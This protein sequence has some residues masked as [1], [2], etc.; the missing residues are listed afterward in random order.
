METLMRWPG[1]DSG[2]VIKAHSVYGL[3]SSLAGGK[4]GLEHLPRDGC[5]P[6]IVG[7]RCTQGSDGA[8]GELVPSPLPTS[9]PLLVGALEAL[10]RVPVE[11]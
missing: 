11:M 8:Q 3:G 9:P 1:S 6:Y 7:Y 10:A 4:A 5:P 2:L